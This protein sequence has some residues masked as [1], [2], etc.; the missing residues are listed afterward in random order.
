MLS[1]SDLVAAF[2][3]EEDRQW[4]C[5]ECGSECASATYAVEHPLPQA[6]L[7]HVKRFAADGVTGAAT[8]KAD[9]IM[10]DL[11][12]SLAPWATRG[13]AQAE[14]GGGWGDGGSVD[15]GCSPMKGGPCPSY[16]LRS[17]VLHHGAHCSSGHYTCAA[18]LGSE[19]NAGGEEGTVEAGTMEDGVRG[20]V[21]GGVDGV[22]RDARWIE[23]DDRMTTELPTTALASE[24]FQKGAYL[25]LYQLEG[26]E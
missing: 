13:A 24:V 15:G 2:L 1:V 4:R 17:V 12:L 18:R 6:L 14:D 23:F 3:A 22:S 25:L 19:L 7:L 10:L 9:P 26:G 16:T 11:D 5:D 20:G 8:K 21:G